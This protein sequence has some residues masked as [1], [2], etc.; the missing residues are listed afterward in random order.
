MTL[1]ALVNA[2]TLPFPL[3]LG[4]QSCVAHWVDLLVNRLPPPHLS[5]SIINL[6]TGGRRLDQVSEGCA[7]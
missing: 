4:L 2:E 6:G 1:P 7:P 3:I 5:S